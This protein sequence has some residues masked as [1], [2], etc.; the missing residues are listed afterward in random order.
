MTRY[1][2]ILI[3]AALLLLALAA[4]DDAESKP[5]DANK[6]SDLAQSDTAPKPS[7]A[8][9]AEL[10]P[11]TLPDKV[12][13]YYFH[14]DYRCRTCTMMEKLADRAI[15]KHFADELASGRLEWKVANTDSEE[16]KHFTSD[17]KL[18]TKSLIVSAIKGGK[19]IKWKNCGKIWEH[20]RTPPDY[21]RYVVAE[22]RAYLDG[23]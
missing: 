7:P 5:G 6:A 12:I 23:V 16:N 2:A 3:L 17:Y 14:G 19:Q 9:A 20:V 4:C 1:F 15:K 21:E 10:A 18:Y 13:V 11:K 8:P 22:I